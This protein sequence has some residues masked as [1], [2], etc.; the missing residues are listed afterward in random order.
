[1]S[2]WQWQFAFIWCVS[3]EMGKTT[4]LIHQRC[5]TWLSNLARNTSP[6]MSICLSFFHLLSIAMGRCQFL[7]VR[8]PVLLKKQVQFMSPRRAIRY[9]CP[10]GGLRRQLCF[11]IS[12]HYKN[13]IGYTWE[14]RKG[15]IFIYIH[16]V[17]IF[18]LGLL[19]LACGV[20][21]NHQLVR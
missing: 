10:F 4:S 8:S 19:R 9:T 21:A 15:M 3:L 18:L 5:S 1:M 13:I 7:V 6:F 12:L 20:H 14:C 2:S 16:S 17:Y 11:R